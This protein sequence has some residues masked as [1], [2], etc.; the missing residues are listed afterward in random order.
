MLGKAAMG[1]IELRA[2]FYSPATFAP[3]IFIKR[4]GC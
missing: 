4:R 2:D 3:P 1:Q